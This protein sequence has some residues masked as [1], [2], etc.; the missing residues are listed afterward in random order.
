MTEYILVSQWVEIL[1]TA[2]YEEAKKMLDTSNAKRNEYV[3][4]CRENN[5]PSVDNEIFMYSIDP[6][7]K[8]KV[9]ESWKEWI[10]LVEKE[11]LIKYIYY[12]GPEKIHNCRPMSYYVLWA[13]WK[14]KSVIKAI[15]NSRTCA[16][17]FWEARERKLNHS[18]AVVAT[19]SRLDLF[20]IKIEEENI[21]II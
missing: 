8:L 3:S 16:I 10:Y 14:K 20:D 17:L 6:S 4:N 21:E 11:E 7:M 5:E 13:D 19:N 9:T 15:E 12:Y 18:L 1:R 2:N